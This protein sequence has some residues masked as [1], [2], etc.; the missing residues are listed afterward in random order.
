MTTHATVFAPNTYIGSLINNKKKE[1]ITL[2]DSMSAPYLQNANDTQ[3]FNEFTESTIDPQGFYIRIDKI[4]L[5]KAVVKD[6][7]PRYKDIYVKSWEKGVS[8]GKFT[9]YPDQIG[10][11][12]LF[13]HALGNKETA[14]YQ[15][16][17]FSNMDQVNMGD[18]VI[19]YYQ[20]K[21]YFYE[22]DEIRAVDPDATGFYTGNAPVAKLRMQFCGPPTGSLNKRTLV[23]ALLVNTE[24]FGG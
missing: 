14:V 13:S 6:V 23:D 18:E 1:N 16:A 4:K 8:H 15:N 3:T 19:I 17:W 2:E 7:D 20:G 22:V 21:K 9:A 12:Y 24:D 5:F 11:T 10:I